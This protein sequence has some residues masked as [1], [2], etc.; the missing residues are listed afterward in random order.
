M[1]DD[2]PWGNNDGSWW[3]Q[4]DLEMQEREEQERIAA[5]DRAITEWKE[6]DDE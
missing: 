5:C 6:S 1:F 4:L 3:H 2:A